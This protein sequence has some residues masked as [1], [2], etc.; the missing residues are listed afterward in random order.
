MKD[1]LYF[2]L[3]CWFDSHYICTFVTLQIFR[4]LNDLELQ[5]FKSL[6]Y[7]NIQLVKSCFFVI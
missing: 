6:N 2:I 1:L 5:V 4:I 3:Q 7:K